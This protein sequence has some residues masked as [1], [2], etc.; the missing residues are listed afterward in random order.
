MP[1]TTIPGGLVDA[2]AHLTLDL[3]DVGLAPGPGR[4]AVNIAA[5]HGA[6][7][8]AI[9]DAGSRSGIPPELLDPA[10][11]VAAS[12]FLAPQGGPSPTLYD[13]VAPSELVA[14]VEADARAGAP[15]IKVMA[16]YPGPDGNWF[17]P[18]VLYDLDLVSEAVEVA[19]AHGARVMAHVSGPI[20]GDLV[21]AGVDSIEHGPLVDGPLVEEMARRGTLWC[22]TVATIERHLRPLLDDVPEVRRTFQRWAVTLPLAAR[23]GVP[24]LAGSDELGPRGVIRE[25]E[26]LVRIGTL[27]PAEALHAATVAPREAL[28]L[29]AIDGDAVVV[30]GDPTEDV[31]ALGRVVE[32]RRAPAAPPPPS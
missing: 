16:D 6:G 27:S 5:A 13:P 25:V 23:L 3:D 30:D 9:R 24:V 15:W 20:V 17:A 10:R 19:H 18:R 7:V 11:H 8:L 28:G 4:V 32:V 26:A 12:R 31:S 29:A 1:R 22:P 2:H 21:R 14:A